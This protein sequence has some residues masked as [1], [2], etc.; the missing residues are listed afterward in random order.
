MLLVQN[1]VLRLVLQ[2]N[3]SCFTYHR[4]IINKHEACFGGGGSG[5]KWSI[6]IG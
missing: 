2:K 3:I 1:A 4:V 5:C 6:V